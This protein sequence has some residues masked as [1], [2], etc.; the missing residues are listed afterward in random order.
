[1]G[2]QRTASGRPSA[3]PLLALNAPD[4]SPM[5]PEQAPADANTRRRCLPSAM[6]L[7]LAVRSSQA[8]APAPA[9][10]KHIAAGV[11]E[12]F[13]PCSRAR[14]LR[15]FDLAADLRPHA[16]DLGGL[17]PARAG[18]KVR[19]PP[20][21]DLPTPV[22]FACRRLGANHGCQLR[23]MEMGWI[24][25]TSEFFSSSGPRRPGRPSIHYLSQHPDVL[26]SDPKDARFFQ[27]E[28][29]RGLDYYISGIF[30]E[31]CWST[32]VGDAAPQHL[33]LPYAARRDSCNCTD[34]TACGDLSR[35]GRAR[36]FGLLEQRLPENETR[37]FDEADEPQVSNGCARAPASRSR[38][39]APTTQRSPERGVVHLQRAFGFCIE[40]GYYARYIELYQSLFGKDKLKIL[41]FEDLQRDPNG[42]INHFSS[43]WTC[44]RSHCRI[45]EPRTRP[46]ASRPPGSSSW[47]AACRR[48]TAY[49]LN[50]WDQDQGADRGAC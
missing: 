4:R 31:L 38:T 20:L 24:G 17:L 22:S 45:P 33:Y 46:S 34:G 7:L 10:A 16:H 6:S 15:A 36:R 9:I 19:G 42:T 11:I 5:P 47:R 39:R 48:S 50:E 40:P 27:A 29:E 32:V 23:R 8:A 28:Y 41:F 26:M 14:E 13:L 37:S 3:A 12:N 44:D 2:A 1:M 30:Q 49:P 18:R 35:S 25:A 21:Q 43:S